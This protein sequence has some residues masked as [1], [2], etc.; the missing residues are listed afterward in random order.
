VLDFVYV[1]ISAPDISIP[2]AVDLCSCLTIGS[3]GTVGSPRDF[4]N[5]LSLRSQALHW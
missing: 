3:A 4:H 1:G 2:M 5:G